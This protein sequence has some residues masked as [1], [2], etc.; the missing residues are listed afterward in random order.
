MRLPSDFEPDLAPKGS[1]FAL[2]KTGSGGCKGVGV[3]L[4]QQ[5]LDNSTPS[6]KVLF[7]MCG[8]FAEFERSMI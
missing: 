3:Y 4:H 7:Q 1:A 6:G 8:V 5:A 2:D